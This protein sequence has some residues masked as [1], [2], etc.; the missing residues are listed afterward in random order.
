LRAS[1]RQRLR[2]SPLTDELRFARD[3]EAAM[4]RLWR[5][6]CGRRIA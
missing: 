6:W 2:D 4:R 1:L 3:M 5:D